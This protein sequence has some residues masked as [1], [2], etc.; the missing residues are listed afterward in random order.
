MGALSHKYNGFK[1]RTGQVVESVR[2]SELFSQKRETVL[3]FAYPC[4]N[5]IDAVLTNGLVRKSLQ[6][7]SDKYCK[8]QIETI[9]STSRLVTSDNYPRLYET[10]QCCCEK[11]NVEFVPEL[12]VTPQLKGV[13]ALSVGTDTE[14]IIL[15]SPQA[16]VALRDA[17][18]KFMIGHELGHILQQNLMCHT[19]KGVLDALNDKSDV[20]GV[21]VG[22]LIDIPL[23][24]W[25]RCVEFTADRAGYICCGDIASVKSLF[26][27]TNQ[28]NIKSGYSEFMEL[29]QNHPLVKTRIEKVSEFAE[30]VNN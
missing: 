24:K 1:W 11:L 23:N 15:V 25:Y 19:I 30:T 28:L 22:D 5:Y 6:A 8:K 27:K 7:F 9:K 14:P 4:D 13:N 3:P 12:Y 29:Y 18:L 10:L 26:E 21:M 16:V 20:L 2:S 17:E